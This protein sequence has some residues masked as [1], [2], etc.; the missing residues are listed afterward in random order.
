[1]KNGSGSTRKVIM[2][3]ENPETVWKQL[4]QNGWNSTLKHRKESRKLL[5]FWYYTK[6]A[7]KAKGLRTLKG[8][9]LPFGHSHG[10]QGAKIFP[11]TK[12]IEGKFNFYFSKLL[13]LFSGSLA[14]VWLGKT[15]L[16]NSK[17]YFRLYVFPCHSPTILIS[18]VKY[19]SKTVKWIFTVYL[20]LYLW[21]QYLAFLPHTQKRTIVKNP[22]VGLNAF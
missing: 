18:Q 16:V 9:C 5:S 2:R 19:V 15:L 22:V 7:T 1:M 4:W 13:F 3:L 14:S 10:D 21:C 20:F 6:Y 17:F 11:D 12:R 8:H